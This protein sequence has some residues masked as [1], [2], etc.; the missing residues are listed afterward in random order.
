MKLK[1]VYNQSYLGLRSA[2][3][4]AFG[5]RPVAGG[6]YEGVIEVE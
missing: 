1:R 6:G 4:N 2:Y 5:I 3:P